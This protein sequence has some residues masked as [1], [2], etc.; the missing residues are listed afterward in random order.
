MVCRV[1]GSLGTSFEAFQS[2]NQQGGHLFSLMF[3]VYSDEGVA[4]ADAG[5]RSRTREIQTGKQ[6]LIGV[7]C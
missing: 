5:G 6:G 7:F 3:N 4:L 1:G 2:V